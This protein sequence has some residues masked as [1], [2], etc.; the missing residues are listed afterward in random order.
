MDNL[1]FT[2][3]DSRSVRTDVEAD[4]FAIGSDDIERKLPLGFGELFPCLA[5]VIG[6]FLRGEFDES[7]QTTAET[8]RD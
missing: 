3:F 6:L 7:P 2:V 5:G 1:N 4:G 8:S